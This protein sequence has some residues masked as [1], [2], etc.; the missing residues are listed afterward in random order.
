MVENR[1]GA[2]GNIAFQAAAKADPD[3]YTLMLSTPGVVINPTLYR[4][5]ARF[6]PNDFTPIYIIGDAP[7]LIMIN[8]SVKANTLGELIQMAKQ[9][10]GAI[11]YASAGNGSSSHL[12]SEIFLNMAGLSMLHVPYKGGGAA[13]Q[14]VINGNVEMTSLPIAES[15]PMVTSGRVRALAQTGS[16]RSSIAPDIPTVAEAGLPSYKLTT[17]Y[18][19]LA[20]AKTPAEIVARLA[21]EMEKIVK[22]PAVQEQ[23]KRSGIDV[24]GAGPERATTFMKDEFTKYARL[25]EKAGVQLD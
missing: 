8:P 9:K 2:G 1:P 17:W 13:F 7:L 4:K 20:P 14:D 23:L 18:V 16:R 25:L 21:T 3:G 10:P 12:A 24:I 19:L 6:S 15:L 11:R 22:T 5:S